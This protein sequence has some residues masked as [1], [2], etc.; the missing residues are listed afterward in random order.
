MRYLMFTLLTAGMLLA[1]SDPSFAQQTYIPEEGNWW[2]CQWGCA[3][4]VPVP[5]TLLL[6]AAGFAGFVGWRALENRG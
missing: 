3:E 6:F 1:L 2:H 5:A 4:Q